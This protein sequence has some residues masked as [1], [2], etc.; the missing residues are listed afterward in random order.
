MVSDIGQF[1]FLDQETED[2]GV[3]GIYQYVSET[4]YSLLVNTN[5]KLSKIYSTWHLISRTHLLDR[6]QISN[7]VENIDQ[8][9]VRLFYCKSGLGLLDLEEIIALREE[10]KLFIKNVNNP[11]NKKIFSERGKRFRENFS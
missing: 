10:I 3:Y 11:E 9:C 4:F 8:R 7:N 2:P 6:H 5:K 1:R